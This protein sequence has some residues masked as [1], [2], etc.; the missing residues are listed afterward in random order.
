MNHSSDNAA[1]TLYARLVAAYGPDFGIDDFR[2][3]PRRRR[4]S[5]RR[6]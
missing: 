1:D 4:Q 5:H 6:Q 2:P 3:D